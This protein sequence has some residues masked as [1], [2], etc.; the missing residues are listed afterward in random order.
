MM[1]DWI[2]G[3]VECPQW[4]EAGIQPYDTGKIFVC[5]PDGTVRRIGT[6]KLPLEGSHD[7]RL[8]VSSSQGHN[9]Y[10][11]G[12]PV[13]HIQGHNLFGSVDAV[14]LFLEA[15]VRV[16][17]SIG[18]FPSP[19]TWRG[20]EFVGPRFTRLDI[21]RSYRFAT[22]QDARAWIRDVA[23][24]ARSRHGGAEF[25]KGETAY[26]GKRSGQWSFKV[27][28]KFD[29]LQCGKRGHALPASL[30]RE[31]Y[32]KLIAWADGV[33]RFELSLRS[34]EIALLDERGKFS[35]PGP[36]VFANATSESMLALWQAYY[37]RITW[38][39]NSEMGNPDLLDGSLSSQLRVALLAWRGG[40]DL[41][42]VYARRT[43][44]RV[45][46]ELLDACGVDIASPYVPPQAA[47]SASAAL[48]PRGWDPEPLKALAHEPD[49]SLRLNY[50]V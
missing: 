12:N 6:G 34:K 15:G 16:R 7:S 29:E 45:R 20:N 18:V 36:G 11:S 27:Y 17:Q 13:K 33:V 25:E 41:R 9:L 2:S 39:R 37:D 43:W 21:T 3:F 5:D 8:I 14:G 30:S 38:N 47:S 31:A 22:L 23:A 42:K 32:E 10:L 35:R 24:N 4:G 28:S 46:R 26:F 44:Y 49:P 40:A 19:E 1:V 48:D 50:G